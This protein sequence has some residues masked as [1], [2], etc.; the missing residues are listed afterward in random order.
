MTGNWLCTPVWHSATTTGRPGS[1]NLAMYG[2]TTGEKDRWGYSVRGDWARTTAA[3]RESSTGTPPSPTS[4]WVNNT[5][6][7][8]TGYAFEAG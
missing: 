2:E 1:P 8:D 3:R 7:I 4:V 5:L 6:C